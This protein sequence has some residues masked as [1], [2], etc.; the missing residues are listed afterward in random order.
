MRATPGER[1]TVEF[2]STPVL[3]RACAPG[4][5]GRWDFASADG[6]ALGVLVEIVTTT[7]QNVVVI[8]TS[9]VAQVESDGSGAIDEANPIASGASGQIKARAKADGTTTRYWLGY[10]CSPAAATAALLVDVLI[11]PHAASNT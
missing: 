1:I 9:G 11:A 10:A 8:Q 3:N 7:N 6:L 4:T 2:A 5:D